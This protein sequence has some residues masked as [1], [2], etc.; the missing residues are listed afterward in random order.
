MATIK[1]NHIYKVYDGGVKAVNDFT[2]D[3][4]DKEF[5][6][7]VGPS[8]CGKSTTLRMIA[9][10]EEISSGELFINNKYCNDLEPKDRNISMV[11]QSY[12]LFPNMTVAQNISFG[13]RMHHEDRD[14]IKAKVN[15][16]AKILGLETYLNRKPKEL[17]GGQ[18]QRVALGRAIVRNPSVFLF[19]EP[20]SNL[21]AKLRT[22]M[23][24]EI[25]RLHRQLQTTFVYVTHDQTEAMT[26]A[27]RI[28]CMKDG[29][30]KQ[31]DTPQNLYL[32]PNNLFVAAFI[33]TPQMNLSSA[34]VHHREKGFDI[35]S[36]FGRFELPLEV[37]YK[38]DRISLKEN[39]ESVL[40]CRAEDVTLEKYASLVKHP[41]RV[42]GYISNIEEL[43]G[44]VLIYANTKKE[45]IDLENSPSAFIASVPDHCHLAYGDKASFIINLDRVHLFD[46][47]SEE[48]IVK[49]VPRYNVIPARIKQD[50]ISI[51]NQRLELP[52]FLLHS[53]ESEN[54]IIL[55]V[56]TDSLDLNKSD[57]KGQIVSEEK[58]NNQY[59]YR[60]DVQG[61]TLHLLGS[62]KYKL[63]STVSFGFDFKKVVFYNSDMK[64]L[65]PAFDDSHRVDVTFEKR[66]TRERHR[67]IAHHY[68][69][70]GNVK[71]RSPHQVSEALY[72]CGRNV[73]KTKL[74]ASLDL[75]SLHEDK[76]GHLVP[77]IETI[78]FEDD[79]YAIVK[80]NGEKCYIKV[81]EPNLSSVRISFDFDRVHIYKKELDILVY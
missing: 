29:F 62:H 64:V 17:S 48:A 28:V 13:L 69:N 52:K 14:V 55:A 74:Q 36:I 31:I 67:R 22:K 43:G 23:R 2:I 11:F 9:G 50:K 60:L 38:V 61:E 25:K 77:V 41:F 57:F 10:L 51:F 80:I 5:V 24:T 49:R 81:H 63:K 35:D 39:G 47:M 46:K 1:L 72:A 68:L 16:V 70:F 37:S 45:E 78:K 66:I 59:L 34:I 75:D 12:A 53:L 8:G 32:Y 3:I 76:N 26:M 71:V 19:D 44:Q 40:G 4:A 21:D 27:D 33:G 54:E 79:H 20:L 65:A 30:V 58:I 56:P 73:F 18:R 15:E 7:F 42:E 6:V